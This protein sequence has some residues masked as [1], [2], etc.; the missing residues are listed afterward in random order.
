MVRVTMNSSGSDVSNESGTVKSTV[1]TE[2]QEFGS[3]LDTL[4]ILMCGVGI[5]TVFINLFA[6]FGLKGCRRMIKQVRLLSINLCIADCMTGFVLIIETISFQADESPDFRCNVKYNIRE[7]FILV[8]LLTVTVLA[9]DRAL[10]LY[11]PFRYNL[12]VTKCKVLIACVIIWLLSGV[13]VV[14]TNINLYNTEKICQNEIMSRQLLFRRS[15]VLSFCL[16][17]IICSYLSIYIFTRKF[18]NSKSTN[19]DGGGGVIRQYI[20]CTVKIAAL[21]LTYPLLAIPL[22]VFVITGSMVDREL[23]NVSKL[24]VFATQSLTL[25]CLFNPIL[26]AWRFRECRL[27]ILVKCCHSKEKLKS[28]YGTYLPQEKQTS[29]FEISTISETVM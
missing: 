2:Y 25:K 19:E 10:C 27:W 11:S 13:I 5:L 14:L 4:Q 6:Y 7:Y 3:F 29:N 9:T 1:S 26:Y 15:T 12:F 16:L 20:R 22:L 24:Q 18:I 17:V 28:L 23:I 21:G 8:S